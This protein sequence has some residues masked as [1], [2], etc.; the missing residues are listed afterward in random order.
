MPWERW[1]L[2]SLLSDALNAATS[3]IAAHSSSLHPMHRAL[4]RQENVQESST[5]LVALQKTGWRVSPAHSEW[6]Q[7]ERVGGGGEEVAWVGQGA[8]DQ[9]RAWHCY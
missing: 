8:A 5:S 2:V 4:Q 6:A 3:T 1:Q 7:R 9:V